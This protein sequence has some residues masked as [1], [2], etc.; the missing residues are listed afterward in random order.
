MRRETDVSDPISRFRARPC[1]QAEFS[2]DRPC[3][4]SPFAPSPRSAA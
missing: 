3:Q 1:P 2:K 4:L